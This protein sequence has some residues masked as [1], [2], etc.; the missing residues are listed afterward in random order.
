[1]IKKYQLKDS[2][3]AAVFYDGSN[4]DEIVHFTDG[5]ASRPFFVERGVRCFTLDTK[6]GDCRV[7]PGTYVVHIRGRLYMAV[8]PDVF[9]SR[10]DE[11]KFSE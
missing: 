8:A 11:V 2:T 1:M 5:K 3:V 10:Y 7:Y 4:F 6:F 9:T